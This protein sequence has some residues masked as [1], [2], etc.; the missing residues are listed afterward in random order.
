M[1]DMDSV[2]QK[3]RSA[4]WSWSALVWGSVALFDATQT[5][6]V[7]HSEGMQHNWISLF[8]TTFLSFLPWF[9]ATP[10]VLKLGRRF[11][12]T[13]LMPLSTWLVHFAVCLAVGA[14]YSGWTAAFQHALNPYAYSDPKTFLQLWR[15]L[16]YNG[17][18]SHVILYGLILMVGQMLESREKIARQQ[19]EAAQL[20]DALSRAQLDALRRQIEPHFLF[21]TLNSIAGL[22]REKRNEDAVRM[23]AGLSDCLRRVLDGSQKQEATLGE[24]VEFLEKYLEIQKARFAERLNVR[25]EVDKELYRAQVPSLILQPM[26]ENAIQHGIA[27]RTRGGNVRVGASQSDGVLV[28]RVYNDGPSLPPDWDRSQSGIGIPNVRNRLQSLYGDAGG[29]LI[30]NVDEGVEVSLTV[31]YRENGTK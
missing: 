31:P 17:L 12:P 8:L 7:M 3:L 23:I 15:S 30:R 19:T 21:N 24:E 9:V 28:L 25:V 22:V 20:N 10:L 26:V 29:V 1:R 14:V 5:V 6:V 27:R 11:P 16:F 18:L 4:N 2:H 13:R